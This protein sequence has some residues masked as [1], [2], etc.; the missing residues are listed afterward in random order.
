MRDPI[1]LQDHTNLYSG[2]PVCSIALQ[3]RKPGKMM[4]QAEDK[5]YTILSELAT[6]GAKGEGMADLAE[7]ALRQATEILGIEAAALLLWNDDHEASLSAVSARSDEDRQRLLEIEEDVFEMLRK[8]RQLATAYMSFGGTQP[9]Q[10]FTLP[11]KFGEIVQGAV[12]GIQKGDNPIVDEHIFLETLV[13]LLALNRA[14]R[15]GG[16][17]GDE[18]E[19]ALERERQT[20]I[21]QTAV[22][23]NHEVNN[24]LTA[25]L[26]NVQLLLLKRDD[27][28]EE[29][30][31]KLKVI[32]E[33][34]MRIKDVT[35]SLM[36]IKTPRSVEYTKG[37]QMLDLNGEDQDE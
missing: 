22:T 4:S 33:S 26:G 10:S 5:K 14:A 30:R 11:L 3:V 8:K 25:I 13:S 6:S 9:F 34:A 12:I 32:E 37:T 31:S 35:Q 20:T 29:L 27:L 18:Y 28:D 7:T 36:K 16:L 17:S 24:P 21:V 15:S 19:Q 2:H 23:I 1:L